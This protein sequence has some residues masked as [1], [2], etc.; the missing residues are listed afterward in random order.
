MQLLARWLLQSTRPW[1]SQQGFLGR[2]QNVEMVRSARG[3]RFSISFTWASFFGQPIKKRVSTHG[4]DECLALHPRE[5]EEDPRFRNVFTSCQGPVCLA[6]KERANGIKP[7]LSWAA[8]PIACDLIARKRVLISAEMN[9]LSRSREEKSDS[10]E[11][12]PQQNVAESPAGSKGANPPFGDRDQDT[13]AKG[14]TVTGRSGR[15]LDDG[16]RSSDTYPGDDR[17]ARIYRLFI[18]ATEMLASVELCLALMREIASSVPW[19]RLREV[20]SCWK[21]WWTLSIRF[22]KCCFACAVVQFHECR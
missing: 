14:S 13:K 4:R 7:T 5:M 18:H 15:R 17:W 20:R 6:I 19:W 12:E 10:V 16:S 1:S 21:Q 3:P 9:F 22:V 2:R 8:N 11:T